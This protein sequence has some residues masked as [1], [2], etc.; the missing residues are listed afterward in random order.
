[1]EDYTNGDL[2]MVQ[3]QRG[4][5]GNDVGMVAWLMVLKTVEYPEVRNSK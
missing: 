1:M 3:V 4:A 2:E 5:G